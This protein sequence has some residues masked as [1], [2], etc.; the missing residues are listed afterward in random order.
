ASATTGNDYH[1]ATGTAVIPAGQTSTTVGILVNG[2]NVMEPDET[3]FLNLINGSAINAT[4]TCDN[5]GQGTILDDEVTITV[6]A[7]PNPALTEAHPIY[8]FPTP[9]FEAVTMTVTV[10]HLGSTVPTGTITFFDGLTSFAS[11]PLNGS[12]QA[13]TVKA[14]GVIGT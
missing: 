1:A 9:T 11:A 5:Q 4:T 2:D 13:S 10:N 12:A 14:F 7:S 6:V 8:P 3:F